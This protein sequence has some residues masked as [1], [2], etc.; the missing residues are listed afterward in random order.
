MTSFT[1][2][3]LT[4]LFVILFA[5]TACQK[6]KDNPIP[7]P[8]PKNDLPRHLLKS[9]AWDNGMQSLMHYNPDSTVSHITFA[10][11]SA[12]GQIIYT[13]NEGRLVEVYDDRSLYTNQYVYDDKGRLTAIRNTSRQGQFNVSYTLEYAYDANNRLQALRY[14][15]LNQAGKQLQE[16]TTYHYNAA[17]SL[18]KMETVSG[19]SIIIRQIDAWSDRVQFDY[20]HFISASISEHYS[21][22]N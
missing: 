1:R 22:Y 12:A 14:Y 10:L 3:F 6:E 5:L 19:T 9:I 8:D 13:W 15:R 4:P 7:N 11:G 20:A 2:H 16:T 21:L 18:V 17:G